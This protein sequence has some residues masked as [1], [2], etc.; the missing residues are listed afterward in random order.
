MRKEEKEEALKMKAMILFFLISGSALL[1]AIIFTGGISNTLQEMGINY[2]LGLWSELIISF[3]LILTGLFF[4]I[5]FK[6]DM[7]IWPFQRI[8]KLP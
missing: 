5:I 8:K 7:G 3:I 4:S 2:K 6:M 1:L